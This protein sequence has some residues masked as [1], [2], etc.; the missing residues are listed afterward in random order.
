MAIHRKANALLSFQILSLNDT[1]P[2]KK[3]TQIKLYS[4]SEG[5]VWRKNNELGAVCENLIRPKTLSLAKY[6]VRSV[7]P[8]DSELKPFAYWL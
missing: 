3:Y 6:N 4:E 7:Y 8:P 5:L 1:I 2:D